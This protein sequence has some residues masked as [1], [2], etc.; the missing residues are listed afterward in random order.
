MIATVLLGIVFLALISGLYV[1]LKKNLELM[2]RLE[3]VE[4]NVDIALKA[5]DEQYQKIDAKSK[6]EVFSDEPIVR[7]L[8]LDISD[9]KKSVHKIAM[10]LDSSLSTEQ[11]EDTEMSSYDEKNQNE[12]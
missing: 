1:S 5:L 2:D 8:L 11:L 10:L 4:E 3:V 12:E 6:I 7:D 9:A